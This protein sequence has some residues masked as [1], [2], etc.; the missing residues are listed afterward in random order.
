MLNETPMMTEFEFL[1]PK[2]LLD[3]EGILHRQGTMR[4]ATAKDEILVQQDRRSHESPAYGVLIMLSRVITKLG[5]LSAVTPEL[6]ET[7]FT[8]D[9]TY[10]RT[11]YDRVNQQ[12]IPQLSVQ[13]PK[14][15]H[16]FQVELSAPGES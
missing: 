4:L 5:T 14:C 6:L 9:V 13:C 12:G 10:L 3:D 8:L 7:L 1:L 15:H 16:P 2:G 11:F